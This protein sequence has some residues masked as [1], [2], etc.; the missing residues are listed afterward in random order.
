MSN[1]APKIYRGPLLLTE[2]LREEMIQIRTRAAERVVDMVA[3]QWNN[4][5]ASH[6]EQMS[7]Q[8][9]LIPPGFIMVYSV[10]EHP[11]AGKARHL[12]LTS[13]EPT[14]MPNQKTVWEV[15]KVMGFRGG[16]GWMKG[17]EACDRIWI[18]GL[19]QGVAVN[20]VQLLAGELSEPH[21]RQDRDVRLCVQCGTML[22]GDSGMGTRRLPSEGDASIC[23]ACGQIYRHRDG[24][25][26]P[27]TLAE[28]EDPEL[29]IELENADRLRRQTIPPLDPKRG[30]GGHA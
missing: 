16:Q 23:L 24:A 28:V 21:R 10:E 22:T 14:Q 30:P 15:A 26:Q 18:E 4:N 27:S 2:Q 20:L 6:R 3:L 29:K 19:N 1:Q 11:T 25:W 12:S 13:P 7:E 5:H 17:F 8:S 9:M